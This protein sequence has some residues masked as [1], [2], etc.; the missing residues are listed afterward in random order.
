MGQVSLIR[1]DGLLKVG[2]G[3]VRTGVTMVLPRGRYEHQ[4]SLWRPLQSEWQ[5]RDDRP[6][7]FAGF[8]SHLRADRHLQHQ[9]PRPGL[10][11]HHAVVAGAF[12]NSDL[13]G[14]VGNL[15]RQAERYRR[16][17]R[18]LTGC[19]RRDRCSQ[20]RPGRGGQCGRRHRHGLFRI[21]GRC[22]HRFARGRHR[23]QILRRR[24][25]RSV[26]HGRPQGSAH[27]GRS[28]RS[29]TR[30]S[31]AL[32]LRGRQEPEGQAAEM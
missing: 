12:R 1:G 9:C 3:P 31:L 19:H 6:V 21:Q 20:G 14:G 2:D 30:R 15:G 16:L 28:R 7:L 13:A 4:G 27:R 24:R 17:P 8:R 10:C 23:K 11:R 5:W 29:R 25:A 18:H 32:L 26:Q 22:R